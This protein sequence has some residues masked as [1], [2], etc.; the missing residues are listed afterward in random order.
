MVLADVDG[1]GIGD[2][3]SSNFNGNSTS[4]LRGHGDGT[5][6]GPRTF[7]TGYW[8][9]AVAVGDFDQD[10]LEDL[11]TANAAGNDAWVLFGRGGLSFW[12][13]QRRKFPHDPIA[14]TAADFDGDGIDDLAAIDRSRDVFRIYPVLS[15]GTLDAY[16]GGWNMGAPQ[17]AI[18]ACDLNGDD[19]PDVITAGGTGEAGAI[20]IRLADPRTRFGVSSTLEVVGA[21]R[22]LVA[23]DLDRDGAPDL[24]VSRPTEDALA[25]FFGHGDGTFLEPVSLAAGDSPTA[26]AVVDLDGN[27]L[28]DLAA[29]NAQSND[30]SVI[31]AAGS[32]GFLPQARTPV[33][34]GPL[35]LE[36]GDVNGDA[37]TDLVV[38]HA[39]TGSLVVIPGHGDGSF[40]A[41]ISSP[42]SP[43]GSLVLCDVNADGHLDAV[44]VNDRRLTDRNFIS[45]YPGNGAG[46][47]AEALEFLAS[48]ASTVAIVRGDFNGDAL[49][50]LATAN[51]SDVVTVGDLA[52]LVNS[53]GKL[54]G[55]DCNENG[56]PD[57]CDIEEGRSADADAS[58][59]PDECELPLQLT[60]DCNQDGMIDLSDVICI[61][62]ALFTEEPAVFPCGD[63]SPGDPANVSLF[64]GQG[65][66]L[67]NITDAVLYLRGFLLGTGVPG[68]LDAPDGCRPVAGCPPHPAC[69]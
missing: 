40:A 48:Y 47:F 57:T 41:T 16:I 18:A 20:W 55:P 42:A 7:S 58:G 34:P 68:L 4:V 45:V 27:G 46:S 52:V 50:D 69:R 36:A 31:L 11:A 12:T 8:P 63:G 33:S 67:V 59:V 9:A 10:G 43:T 56:L 17:E 5:F 1:D 22:D 23:V 21:C 30:V 13:A 14:L 29:C 53:S 6:D 64:D 66:G 35:D 24:V 25:V 44:G 49:P 60:G 54:R 3:V 61:L 51:I 28:P 2:L 65:D 15:G 26:L 39:G 38:S 37:H 19:L 62:N 32:R